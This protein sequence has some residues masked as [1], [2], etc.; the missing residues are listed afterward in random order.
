MEPLSKYDH[1]LLVIATA[2]LYSYFLG[3]YLTPSDQKYNHFHY[4]AVVSVHG[5]HSKPY[6]RIVYTEIMN[7]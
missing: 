7:K 1:Q 3:P 5:M 6:E 4:N 2:N